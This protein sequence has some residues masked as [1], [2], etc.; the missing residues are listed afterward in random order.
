MHDL[1]SELVEKK[2]VMPDLDCTFEED[3]L[4]KLTMLSNKMGSALEKLKAD[5]IEAEKVA[6]NL[7][8]GKEYHE[9]IL[10]DMDAL[11]KEADAAEA[12]VPDQYLPY[13]TYAQML[14]SLR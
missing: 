3:T 8:K 4:K 7:A 13:P 5:T 2:T 1:S 11:R 6:D 14:F 10:T 12:L 9:V